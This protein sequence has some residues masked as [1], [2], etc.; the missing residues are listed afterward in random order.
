MAR[1]AKP[2]SSGELPP[3]PVTG[4]E[5]YL[6]AILD[7]LRAMRAENAPPRAVELKEPVKVQARPRR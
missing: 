7:E 4:A 5:M 2:A 6:A 3:N 1:A